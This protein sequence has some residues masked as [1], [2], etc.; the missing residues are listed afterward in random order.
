MVLGG[1]NDQG[2]TGV[3][4]GF[5]ESLLAGSWLG[6]MVGKEGEGLQLSGEEGAGD[7]VNM[8]ADRAG[9]AKAKVMSPP[10][11]KLTDTADDLDYSRAIYDS[12][13]T[14]EPNPARTVWAI[15]VST[16]IECGM[17]GMPAP[18]Q[19]S[20]GCGQTARNGGV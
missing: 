16:G 11:S 7:F 8:V 1:T 4:P 19:V 5:C 3:C 12:Q 13:G 17:E 15:N 2:V 20:N 6:T 9:A 10:A 18:K 14:R